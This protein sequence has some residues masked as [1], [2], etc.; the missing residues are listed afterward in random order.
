MGSGRQRA[1]IRKGGAGRGFAYAPP[2]REV[3]MLCAR[4]HARVSVRMCASS[5]QRKGCGHKVGGQDISTR[6][7]WQVYTFDMELTNGEGAALSGWA[8]AT[9]SGA[10]PGKAKSGAGDD[11]GDH[12]LQDV[13]LDGGQ[14]GADRPG[15]GEEEGGA[16]SGALE[17][18][19]LTVGIPS[20]TSASFARTL[21]R[22]IDLRLG[23]GQSLLI[24]GPSGSGKTS[25]LRVLCGLWEAEAGEI[26]STGSSFFLP[27]RVYMPHGS[28]TDCL[29]YPQSQALHAPA[30]AMVEALQ[31]VGLEKLE[32]EKMDEATDWSRML[33]PGE[34]QRLSF[35][36]LLYRGRSDKV[37]LDEATSALDTVAESRLYSI[38]PSLCSVYVSVGH[39]ETLVQYHTH[40][41]LLEGEASGGRWQVLPRS[42]YLQRMQS[43]A[44]VGNASNDR[45]APASA[46]AGWPTDRVHQRR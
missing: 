7:L 26:L 4:V 37:F 27:Q 28:L 17:L 42:E 2:F 25:L 24:M 33:S 38:L 45:S 11:A 19:G 16:P 32:R 13:H 46:A 39:R 9:A 34:Q 30:A 14:G 3:C 6:V 1:S 23:P 15:E 44:G 29:C 40:V 20:A 21:V 12:E 35:A 43:A 31:T 10:I 5:C 41:L 8:L 22:G 18:A 36:R